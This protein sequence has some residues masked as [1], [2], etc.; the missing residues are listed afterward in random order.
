MLA[1]GRLLGQTTGA[2]VMAMMFHTL[3]SR[4]TEAALVVAA[5]A[6]AAAGGLSMLRLRVAATASA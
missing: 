6:A 2:V 5:V 3:S 4:P 1:T